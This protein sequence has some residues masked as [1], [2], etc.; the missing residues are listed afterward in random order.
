MKGWLIGSIF[1]LGVNL[2]VF[3]FRNHF[4][5]YL[6]LSVVLLTPVAWT[7][8]YVFIRRFFKKTKRIDL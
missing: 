5:K 6:V 1:V 8:L 2:I 4:N 7:L 3:L